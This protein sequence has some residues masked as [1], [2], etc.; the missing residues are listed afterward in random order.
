METAGLDD[1]VSGSKARILWWCGVSLMML[2]DFGVEASSVHLRFHA[3]WWWH[4]SDYGMSA[5]A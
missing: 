4:G 1:M 5:F 2:C 3:Q